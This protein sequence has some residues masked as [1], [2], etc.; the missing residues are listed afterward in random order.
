M[1]IN[2][3]SAIATLDVLFRNADLRDEEFQSPSCEPVPNARVTIECR[4]PEATVA[5]QFF[6]QVYLYNWDEDDWQ[7]A[8]AEFPFATWIN[9]LT[10][11][12][13][14]AQPYGGSMRLPF[15]VPDADR[16]V[17]QGSGELRMRLVIY[18]P[19][20]LTHTVHWDLVQL[21]RTSDPL[22]ASEGALR[23]GDHNYDQ[24]RDLTDVAAFTVDY[25][26]S[27]PA[28][29]YNLDGVVDAD[30]LQRFVTLYTQP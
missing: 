12:A 3:S 6:G 4:V 19:I 20:G 18:S 2:A 25:N 10:A 29:D 28:A 21:V 7:L 27:S 16:Y 22:A 5:G 23:A 1:V 8:G 14:N 30:D 17:E 9:T 15:D 24:Q 11:G 13:P 26:A